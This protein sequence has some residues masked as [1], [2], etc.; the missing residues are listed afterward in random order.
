MAV[1]MS[2]ISRPATVCP[3]VQPPWLQPNCRRRQVQGMKLLPHIYHLSPSF[4]SG[5]W[6]FF[7]T[8][9]WRWLLE[10]S[11]WVLKWVI[12][13]NF[14]FFDLQYFVR[15]TG[16]DDDEN[17]VIRKERSLNNDYSGEKP[18]TPLLDTIIYPI[19]MKNLSSEVSVFVD[20]WCSY[21]LLTV[22]FWFRKIVMWVLIH[23]QCLSRKMKIFLELGS[24]GFW[25]YISI[26]GDGTLGPTSHW[27]DP[28]S[29]LKCKLH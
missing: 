20:S 23:F 26:P 21:F 10:K 27:S 29:S 19:H 3:F 15:A 8:L 4:S 24:S 14:I 18:A 13:I 22:C 5:F 25:L 9:V 16:S 6:F 11:W 17:V 7:F 2:P 12:I 1:F 28:T